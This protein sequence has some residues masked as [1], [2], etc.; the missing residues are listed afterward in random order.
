MGA[1]ALKISKYKPSAA[2]GKLNLFV[3]ERHTLLAVE[4]PYE[5]VI[6]QALFILLLTL[7]LGYLYFVAASIL[8]IMARKEADTSTLALQT[9]IAKMEGDYFA[10]SSAVD[11]STAGSAGLAPVHSTQY[12]YRPGNAAAVTIQPNEI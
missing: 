5:R 9:K 8:N 1:H 11:A 7:I 3:R 10:M 12:V 2:Q 4:H 6:R